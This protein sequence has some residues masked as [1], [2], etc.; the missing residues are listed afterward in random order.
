FGNP[1]WVG[2]AEA[3]G[4]R[5][6]RVENSRDFAGALRRSLDHEGPALLV[7]PVDYRE[8]MRLTERLGEQVCRI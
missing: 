4:W 3:F 1:E 8:N 7:A 5:G 6:E 2:L